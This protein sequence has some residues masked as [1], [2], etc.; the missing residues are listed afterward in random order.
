MCSWIRRFEP[1]VLQGGNVAMHFIL[2]IPCLV[3]ILPRFGNDKAQIVKYLPT[4][5]TPNLECSLPKFITIIISYHLSFYGSSQE[6]PRR[7]YS[8]L[9]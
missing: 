8:C 6:G 7:R 9:P 5:S 3:I 4:M 2:L 1:D